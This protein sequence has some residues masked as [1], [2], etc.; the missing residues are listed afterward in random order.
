M[1][2]VSLFSGAGGLDLGFRAAGYSIIASVEQDVDCCAT[3]RQNGFSHVFEEDVELWLAR[4]G[5]AQ[6]QPHVIFGGPPCQP[7]SK[8]AYWSSSSAQGLADVRAD[9][10]AMFMAA[11]TRLKPSCFLIENV[12]GFVTAGGVDVVEQALDGFRTSGLDYRFS[13]RVLNCADFGVPQKRLRFFGVGSLIGDFTFPEPTHASAGTQV[14][15]WDALKGSRRSRNENLQPRG[16]WAELLPTIPEGENYLWHTAKGGGSEL[17]GWRTRYWSFLQKLSKSQPS[18]TIVATP[19]QD[20]GPF[21]WNS[22]HLSSVELAAL[23]TF[24]RG[25][26][27]SG[28][29][30]SK[31][32]QIGNAVPPLMSEILA[33]RIA[34]HLG[35]QVPD[36]LTFALPKSDYTPRAAPPRKLPPRFLSLIGERQ[37]HPGTGKGPSPRRRS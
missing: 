12:P 37:P 14:T 20:A 5:T 15:A 26:D 10:V 9:C 21:H 16:K 11:V 32:R 30:A 31:R 34:Q 23:Q 18:P 17:F 7:F 33:R 3:L 13:W 2:C 29:I 35:G 22:R 36:Q 24:P 4:E 28:A 1:Q 27:L 6:L 8:S 25:Y 19:A